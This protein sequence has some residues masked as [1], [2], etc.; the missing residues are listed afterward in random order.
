ME[1]DTT[2]TTAAVPHVDKYDR[3]LRLWGA[4]G[5]AA[6]ART[7]VVL[8]R[9]TA[10]GTETC[11]NLV[12]PGIGAV[13]VLDD[14]SAAGVVHQQQ[15]QQYCSNFFLTANNSSNHHHDESSS[16]SSNKQG[17]C[18]A[19]MALECLLE[20]N[21]D[22]QG[23]WT[24]CENLLQFDFE[25]AFRAA[26]S[27]T[28]WTAAASAPAAAITSILVVASDVEPPLLQRV[29]SAVAACSNNNNTTYNETNNNNNS[30]SS[31]SIIIPIV[32]VAAYGLLGVVRLQ[33][34]LLPV[35]NPKPR[36]AVPDLRLVQP[37][38][39]LAALA[40]T[41]DF[42]LLEDHQHA[43]VPY[44]L[45][46]LQVMAD[47]YKQ[48]QH[49][50]TQQQ[51]PVTWAE[52]QDFVHKIKAA[53]RNFDT[54]LNFQEAVR[55]AYTAYTARDVD[56]DRLAAIRDT[57]VAAAGGAGNNNTNVPCRQLLALLQALDQFLK[58]HNNA[59]PVHGSI[60]DMTASTEWYVQLQN[61]YREQAAADVA[62]MKQLLADANAAA[63]S[64]SSASSSVHVDDEL[65][66]TFCQNVHTLDLLDTGSCLVRDAAVSPSEEICEN[67]S[68]V[69]QEAG[70]DDER[71]DQLPLLWY[72][73][74][75]SCQLF[76]AEYGR[77]PG[78]T[79]D[80]TQDVAPLQA[81]IVATVQRYKLGDNPVVKATLL[82]SSNSSDVGNSSSS[83][84]YAAE[85]TRYGNAELH[86]V[87]SVVGGVASQEAV[88]LITG[89][90]VPLNN[91]YIYN[92]IASTGA[93]YKL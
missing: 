61:V 83:S 65:V 11:K 40:R 77:Y 13:L 5:Q 82:K 23:S 17:K 48:Q 38:S 16:P 51:L 41:I 81:C 36:D 84:D 7:C 28:T 35:L 86:T 58:H 31:E 71:P 87:A 21:P 46:L 22:V 64:G 57:V 78:T 20:L 53:S 76:F 69:L 44:P 88:K 52:K 67:L 49:S 10:A 59:P 27:K 75:E 47:A 85:L 91:T 42:S 92:G 24:H 90:Y 26:V 66:A 12:L 32:Q 62:E 89:Q 25:A 60:P 3:Q 1:T 74:F 34:P 19:E 55:N 18:R 6:L 4:A 54:E 33:A 45:V 30:Q 15:Q 73:G 9:A 43:H 80:Y 8:I 93:V 50:T 79:D 72:L 68:M 29:A 63:C 14:C 37:F 70:D 2:T 39:A 56:V